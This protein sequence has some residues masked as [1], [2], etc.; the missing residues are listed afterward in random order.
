MTAKTES[1]AGLTVPGR[2][3]IAFVAKLMLYGF[4]PDK[5]RFTELLRIL[6]K[7]WED[8][9]AMGWGGVPQPVAG[10]RDR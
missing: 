7:D 10:G 5:G 8:E 9:G 4:R 2:I 3:V 6:E 1:L